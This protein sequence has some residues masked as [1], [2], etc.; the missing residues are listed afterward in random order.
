M[1][2]PFMGEYPAATPRTTELG[3]GEISRRHVLLEDT[4]IEQMVIACEWLFKG[5]EKLHS[6]ECTIVCQ[7]PAQF[8]IMQ[9]LVWKD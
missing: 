1:V 8:P 5:I 3:T 2:H 9:A 7:A 6:E 4:T